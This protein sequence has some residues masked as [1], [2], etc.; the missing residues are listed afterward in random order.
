MDT[1]VSVLHDATHLVPGVPEH[2]EAPASERHSRSR[3]DARRHGRG[4]RLQNSRRH[5]QAPPRVLV[6]WQAWIARQV[7]RAS[8]DAS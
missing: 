3:T 7:G 4:P 2:G 8:R 1:L 5:H 6:A